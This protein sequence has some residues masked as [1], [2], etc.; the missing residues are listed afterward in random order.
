MIFL[1]GPE[2]LNSLLTPALK[3]PGLKFGSLGALGPVPISGDE[4]P[5]NLPNNPS[6]PPNPP[7]LGL[8]L[9]V[10]TGAPNSGLSP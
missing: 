4:F 2:F 8:P 6:P 5:N 7:L 3:S 1:S 9:K 10:L